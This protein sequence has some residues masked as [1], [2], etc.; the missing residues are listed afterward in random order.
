[1]GLTAWIAAGGLLLL[2]AALASGWIQRLPITTSWLF[3]AAGIVGGPWL[4]DVIWVDF[5]DHPDWLAMISELAL[6]VS[7]FIGG[8]KLRMKFPDVAW[9]TAVRLASVGMLLCIAATC[10]VMHWLF[11]TGWALALL[12]GAM[13][14]PT[15]PVLASMVTVDDA[16]DHD[17]MR[18][19]LS[20]E[21][22]LN[23]GA[24]LP[25]LLLGLLLLGP[26]ASSGDAIRHWFVA[27]ILWS[28]PAGL[29]IGGGIGWLLG[30]LGTRVKSL[31]NDSAPSDF[32]AL[33]IVM[34][35]YACAEWLSASTFLAAFAAGV[36]LRRAELLIVARHP[37]ARADEIRQRQGG[38]EHP[39]AEFL[40]DRT[41]FERHKL[42]PAES[43]GQ[44]V[45]DAL[46]FGDTLERI[47]AATLVFAAGAA[48]AR[49]WSLQAI[50]IALLLFGAIRPGSVYLATIGSTLPRPR[51][52]LMGWLG[53]RGIGTINYMAYAI[54]HG[55]EGDDASMVTAL[56]I[57]TV[58]L[59][60]TLH[61]ATAQPL[62]R[63]RS[64]RIEA[65]GR[66]AGD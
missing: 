64:R 13:I 45:S 33:A 41:P 4:L 62:M 1:M 27:D 16:G 18:G 39:P 49:H 47:L 46:S 52:L 44:V 60:V 31:T 26:D 65:S 9:R 42:G 28:L 24:A 34:L 43:I 12:C 38:S 35:A 61:G 51:R 15:D 22:G 53:I 55:V 14:A 48:L 50:A 23:D 11:G 5:P 7:L 21:A 30:L 8:L 2:L 10:C 54:T 20:G 40:I 32:L 17:A 58:V 37:H 3:L 59:S 6:V 19:S 25:F 57:T 66:D 56:A 63:W 29:A 36:G